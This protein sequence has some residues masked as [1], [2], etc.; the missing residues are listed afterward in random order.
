M[1]IVT[2]IRDQITAASTWPAGAL[3]LYPEAPEN[4]APPFA[5]LYLE[6]RRAERIAEGAKPLRFY[7]GYITIHAKMSV[8]ALETLADGIVEHLEDAETGQR[9]FDVR[10]DAASD[11]AIN[12]TGDE[13]RTINVNFTTG[14]R[15]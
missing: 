8:A 7:D 11:P 3:V 9:F 4:Q 5:V 1:S 15:G 14:M 12:E 6:Q 13:V 10:A 2:D